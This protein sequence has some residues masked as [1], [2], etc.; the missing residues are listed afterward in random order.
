MVRLAR[1]QVRAR[2]RLLRVLLLRH[3]AVGHATLTLLHEQLVSGGADSSTYGRLPAGRSR[4]VLIGRRNQ[5]MRHHVLLCSADAGGLIPGVTRSIASGAHLNRREVQCVIVEAGRRT[6]GFRLLL[7]L[8]L[9]VA[10][11]V[12]A[13]TVSLSR[14]IDVSVDCQLVS[15]VRLLRRLRLS[16]AIVLRLIARLKCGGCRRE[17]AAVEQMTAGIRQAAAL[18]IE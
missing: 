14:C 4:L 5:V 6:A 16:T 17:R 13:A 3:T 11:C 2:E 1:L 10:R 7:T 9:I 15:R 18:T 8:R 12:E